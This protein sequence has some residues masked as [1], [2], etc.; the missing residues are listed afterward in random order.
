LVLRLSRRAAP[1]RLDEGAGPPI[2]FGLD[3]RPES[4]PANLVARARQLALAG[5][6]TAALA[7]L[8]RG[9]L[10]A[11]VHGAGVPFKEG[12]TERD[13]LRRAEH[14]LGTEE[15]SYVARLVRSWQRAA[16]AHTAPDRDA[17]LE[18]CDRWPL[19]FDVTEVRQ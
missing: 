8:Y 4:L 18:L 12:D 11:L 19:S 10:V 16:Y 3:V 14:L 13:C 7:L 1:R 2:L 5:E 15:L 9:T 6:I 17:V